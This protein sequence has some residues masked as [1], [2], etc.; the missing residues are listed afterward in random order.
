MHVVIHP[1]RVFSSHKLAQTSAPST[2]RATSIQCMYVEKC[3]CIYRT[4]I[5]SIL[6]DNSAVYQEPLPFL[7]F[8]K[9]R[10][11]HCCEIFNL[12]KIYLCKQVVYECVPER[13]LD[14]APRA[15][16]SNNLNFGSIL[17]IDSTKKVVRKLQGRAA[18]SASWATNI[19]NKKGEIEMTVLTDAESFSALRRM[20]EGLMCR[21]KTA[22][23]PAPKVLYTD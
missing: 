14:K 12:N 7:P 2:R 22:G 8:P 10:Y 13:C 3:A 9:Q 5:R 4:G 6:P 18:G 16:G 17:K 15:N 23:Q 11:I 21:Y 20:A 19:G 1:P